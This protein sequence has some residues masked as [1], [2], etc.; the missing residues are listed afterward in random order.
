MPSGRR[1]PTLA[2]NHPDGWNLSPKARYHPAK[3]YGPTPCG[4]DCCGDANYEHEYHSCKDAE[5][6]Y[7]HGKERFQFREVRR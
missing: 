7:C 6:V 5:C 4:D 2:P 3:C 1:A